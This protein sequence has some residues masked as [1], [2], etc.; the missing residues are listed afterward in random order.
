MNQSFHGS[1][2]QPI[3]F[4]PKSLALLSMQKIRG[5]TE[6]EDREMTTEMINRW[7]GHATFLPYFKYLLQCDGNCLLQSE[8]LWTFTNISAESDMH[9]AMIVDNGVMPLLLRLLSSPSDEVVEHAMETLSNLICGNVANRDM[10]INLGIIESFAAFE[11]E[12]KS[13]TFHR[14]LAAIIWNLI[15]CESSKIYIQNAEKLLPV[16]IKLFKEGDFETKNETLKS[17]CFIANTDEAH[18]ELI[19]GSDIIPFMI[20]MIS[21]A[22]VDVRVLTGLLSL[23]TNIA[24]GKDEHRNALID[25]GLLI[26]MRFWVL[27][28]HSQIRRLTLMCIANIAGG[29]EMH[30]Q[31]LINTGLVEEVIH[32]LRHRN[33]VIKKQALI[34]MHNL[35]LTASK[36]QVEEIAQ[37]PAVDFIDTICL[38]DEFSSMT[39]NVLNL[40][41]SKVPQMQEQH[42]E[43][44]KKVMQSP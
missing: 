4:Q 24:T 31:S 27:H 37:L 42:P 23:F 25:N 35:I 22:M 20:P 39:R 7:L 29:S 21:R 41:F 12:R 34:T 11:I 26:N 2:T 10:A 38:F 8:V 18:I 44:Y 5:A 36:E 17:F 16:L 19:I 6:L 13:F 30:I 32:A 33:L 3:V 43:M 14:V 15:L 28:R 9:T 1:S 40:L